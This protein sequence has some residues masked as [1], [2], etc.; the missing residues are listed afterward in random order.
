MDRRFLAFLLVALVILTANQFIVAWLFPPP[1]R[2]A[3]QQADAQPG[4]DAAVDADAARRDG[5]EGPAGDAA[6][7]PGDEATESDVAGEADTEL[8]AGGAA[9]D[10]EAAVEE[11]P[12]KFATLGSVDPSSGARLLVVFSSQG[13]TIDRVEMAEPN[14]R[15]IERR[16][17]Y[18][19]YLAVELP[20]SQAGARVRLVPPGTPAESAGLRPGDLIVAV[21]GNPIGSPKGLDAVLETTKPNQEIRLTVERAE[22]ILDLVAKLTRRPLHLIEP[23]STDGAPRDPLSFRMTLAELDGREKPEDAEIADLDLLDANWEL[24]AADENHVEFRQSVPGADLQVFKRFS[25]SPPA[26]NDPGYAIGMEIE[27][28]NSGDAGSTHEVAYW[29]QGPNGLPREGWWYAQRVSRSWSSTGLRDVIVGL[30]HGDYIEHGSKRCLEIIDDEPIS[31][32]TLPVEY[33]GVDAQYF[34]AVLMPDPAGA[35]AGDARWFESSVPVQLGPIPDESRKRNLTNVTFEL[36][37]VTQSLVPGDRILHDFQIVLAPKKP[38]VLANYGL[39]Q[40]LYYGWFSPVSKLL[41]V[42]LHF[43]HDY[44]TFGNYGLAIIMLTVMVRLSMFPLSRKQV[45]GMQKMQE[46]QPEM[47][48]LQEKYK[49][50]PQKRLQ[51]QQKL[52]REANYNPLSGCL[53]VLIQLPIFIGLYRALLVD[54]ELRQAPLITESLGW[55]S[56]LAAPD[57]LFNWESFMPSF[58]VGLLGPYF[59]LLPLATVGLFLWQQKMFMPPPTTEQQAATQKMMNVMMVFMGF[60][61]FKVPSGLCVYFIASSLWGILERKLLPRAAPAGDT[62]SSGGGK[63]SGGGGSGPS[64]GKAP[65]KSPSPIER[66]AQWADKQ[67]GANGNRSPQKRRKQK[68]R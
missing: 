20:D 62:P 51:A 50:D 23:E 21:D 22:E 40:L 66:L 30:D 18:L 45:Q 60:L 67:N 36:T 53:P 42:V 15:D 17:G 59:N 12:E 5:R 1:P 65:D 16:W 58:V 3:A 46:L 38:E 27:I 34:T 68:R 64:R 52:F 61:F 29:L 25:V 26:E 11:H 10:A 31:P 56:N 33:I 8:V 9:D 7:P 44:V 6:A 49:N 35:R 2:P 55:A 28:R 19:G 37:S 41:L 48:R 47:Q 63:S 57:M 14:F 32:W 24:A 4:D 13:A 54:V 39:D 43:F